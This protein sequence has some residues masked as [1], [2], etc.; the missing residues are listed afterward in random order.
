M[1]CATIVFGMGVNCP[2]VRV[3]IHIGPPD[4]REAYIQ[5]PVEPDGMASPQ[6]Q[7]C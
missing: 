7:F 3:V 6:Q 2:D 5:G 1:I 4:D